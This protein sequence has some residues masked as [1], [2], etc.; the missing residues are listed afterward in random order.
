M[1]G[2]SLTLEDRVTVRYG[3]RD[4]ARFGNALKSRSG[5]V[6]VCTLPKSR[7]YLFKSQGTSVTHQQKTAGVIGRW[8]GVVYSHSNNGDGNGRNDARDN[9]C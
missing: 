2:L 9:V 6:F 7:I 1:T 5:K 4:M 3:K 8:G